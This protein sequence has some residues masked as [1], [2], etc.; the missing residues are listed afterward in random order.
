MTVERF[1]DVRDTLLA[2]P[3]GDPHGGTAYV[4]SDIFTVRHDLIRQ[5]EPAPRSV[6]EFGALYGYF[7]VTALEAAGDSIERVYWVDDES[8]TP[9]SNRMCMENLI[10]WSNHRI[11][12]DA[13]T[14]SLIY[15]Y[16]RDRDW[17]ERFTTPAQFDL[18]SVDSDHSYEGCL[19]DLHAAH[20]LNP[21]WIFVDDWTSETHAADIQRATGDFIA[22]TRSAEDRFGV[23]TFA[24]HDTANG[25]AVLTRK[26]W[27]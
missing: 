16:G 15:Q 6:F 8:H 20:R 24:E 11:D 25:L 14:R 5:L 18:V 22:S 9:D 2:L 13:R 10:W 27:A 26:D 4:R 23:Y 21:R 17:P 7:L 19:A 12:L 3:H 1:N